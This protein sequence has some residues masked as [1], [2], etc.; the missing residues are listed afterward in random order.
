[1]GFAPADDPRFVILV[2]MDKPQAS[3]WGAM[4]AAPIFKSLAEELF[5]YFGIPPDEIRLARR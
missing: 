1:V 4:V 3:P 5:A 2:K